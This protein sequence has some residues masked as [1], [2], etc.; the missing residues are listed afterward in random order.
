MG[1]KTEEDKQHDRCVNRVQHLLTFNHK[2]FQLLGAIEKLG[3]ELPKSFITC[4]PCD[5]NVTGGFVVAAAVGEKYQPKILLCENKDLDSE[6]FENTLAHE[7]IHAYDACRAKINYQNCLQH[8][9]TEIRASN[10]SGECSIAAELS[11][12][13]SQVRGGGKECVKRRATLSVS[14]NSS[15]TAPGLAARAVEVALE[16]CINDKCPFDD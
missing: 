9:C 16:K 12:G 13:H 15:C 7:L 11:R 2:I 14:M 1:D 3:C 6:S 5:N 4:G 10:L 8:A